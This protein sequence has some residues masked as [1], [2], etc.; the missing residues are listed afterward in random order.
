M[1]HAKTTETRYDQSRGALAATGLFQALPKDFADRLAAA[2]D[3]MLFE[4]GDSLYLQHDDADWFYFVLSGWV[5]TYRETADGEEAVIELLT[6]GD[7]VGEMAVLGDGA[8]ADNAAA[9]DSVTVLRLPSYLLGQAINSSHDVALKMLKLLAEKRLRQSQEIESLKLQNAPQRIG[10]FVLRQC[11]GQTEGEKALKLP[12]EKSLIATQLGM[13]GET[14]SRA[15]NKLKAATEV[16]TTGPDLNVPDVARLADFVC[17]GC[18]NEY[19]CK[20]LLQVH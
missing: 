11:K 2:S 19:P 17:A 3:V 8:H 12:Y 14:F 1:L 13:K 16:S 7:F 15:L 6:A 9:A 4:K 5:K 10:C 20:D 18:S